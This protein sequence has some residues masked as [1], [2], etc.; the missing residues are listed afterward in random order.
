MHFAVMRFLKKE[1]TAG[2]G[3][4]TALWCPTVFEG[5]K[6]I[7]LVTDTLKKTAAGQFLVYGILHF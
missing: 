6:N 5:F 3:T 2:V 4:K 1:V 7:A